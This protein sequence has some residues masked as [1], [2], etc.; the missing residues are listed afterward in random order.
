L[1]HNC[2]A[3]IRL[4]YA[5]CD[6]GAPRRF[7]PATKKRA[8]ICRH[9]FLEADS[10]GCPDLAGPDTEAFSLS[11]FGFLASLLLR[12][13]PLAMARLLCWSIADI[14]ADVEAEAKGGGIRQQKPGP[15]HLSHLLRGMR[16]ALHGAL[17][18]LLQI[19]LPVA[20]SGQVV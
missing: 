5:L 14:R 10:A 12:I 15:P 7:T 4:K 1:R 13:C 19:A 20:E 18:A 17:E 8:T 6:H 16:L 3:R 11:F 9:F 2:D